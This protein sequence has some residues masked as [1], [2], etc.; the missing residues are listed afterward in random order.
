[1]NRVRRLAL[2]VMSDLEDFVFT[3]HP[4]DQDPA[5]QWTPEDARKKIHQNERVINHHRTQK[6]LQEWFSRRGIPIR[7]IYG[8]H[9][10]IR[11]ISK[12]GVIT[13]QYDNQ[14]TGADSPTA[15]MIVHNISH[16]IHEPSPFFNDQPK[17]IPGIEYYEDSPTKALLHSFNLMGVN[18][19]DDPAYPTTKS[20]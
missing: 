14:D 10:E 2:K 1:M 20:Y 13:F 8:D 7:I 12:P 16:A 18:S 9:N 15:W 17:T 3:P 4:K 19:P 5:W 6:K 11:G